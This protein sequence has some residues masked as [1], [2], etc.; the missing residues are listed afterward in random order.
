M[1]ADSATCSMAKV[2]SLGLLPTSLATSAL[3]IMFQSVTSSA[4][5]GATRSTAA[6]MPG[7]QV[8]AGSSKADLIGRLPRFAVHAMG[9]FVARQGG[10]SHV[11]PV[12]YFISCDLWTYVTFGRVL[13]TRAAMEAVSGFLLGVLAAR[14]CMNFYI[15]CTR[16]FTTFPPLS[17]FD[18][19]L[20]PS[21]LRAAS[22]RGS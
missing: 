10:H 9:C 11:M 7:S 1:A 3:A 5:T 22:I 4:R 2:R 20:R 19:L 15:A 21:G 12:L 14:G 6:T 17:C 8:G 13:T 18:F 16:S